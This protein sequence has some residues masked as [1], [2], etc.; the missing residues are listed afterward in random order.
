MKV[1][2]VPEGQHSITAYLSL[3]DA[4]EAIDFFVPSKC[5]AR[6]TPRHDRSRL[7]DHF[8]PIV[9]KKSIFPKRANID[10]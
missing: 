2:S 6:Y 7:T 8:W 4:S 5:S 3:P 10:G 9:L 1:R